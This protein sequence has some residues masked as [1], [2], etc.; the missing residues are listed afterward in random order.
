M[1]LPEKHASVRCNL[2][3]RAAYAEIAAAPNNY[4]RAVTLSV[5]RGAHDF[6][7]C[8]KTDLTLLCPLSRASWRGLVS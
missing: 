6:A 8:P 2:I 3:G 1:I 7:D 5:T 4:Q